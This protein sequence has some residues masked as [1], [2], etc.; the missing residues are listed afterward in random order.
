M[1]NEKLPK[2]KIFSGTAATWIVLIDVLAITLEGAVFGENIYL[3]ILEHA[4]MIYFLCEMVYKN[5][6]MGFLK[7]W[8][9]FKCIFQGVLAILPPAFYLFFL[10]SEMETSA[11]VPTAIV[12]L[13]LFRMMRLVRIIDQKEREKMYEAFKNAMKKS[14][15]ILFGLFIFIFSVAVL[16]CQLF[17]EYS[18]ELF[19]TPGR[20]LYSVFRLFTIEGWYE[21]PDTISADMTEVGA[22]FVKLYFILLLFVGGIIGMSLLNSVIVDAMVEDN[23]D[24]IKE[25]L[26]RLEQKIDALLKE[27]EQKEAE[28]N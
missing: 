21:I 2:L 9:N 4:C 10:F 28:N 7:Y 18:Q 26:K 13:R 19:G 15:V 12:I 27:K 20:A 23:N 3:S 1:S 17:G 11:S 5:C 6:R 24:D 8:T 16:S 14:T 22:F 25:D